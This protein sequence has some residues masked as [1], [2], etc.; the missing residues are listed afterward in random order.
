MAGGGCGLY[1]FE[2]NQRIV[3]L[4]HFIFLLSGIF[5]LCI[6][7]S[8]AATAAG[9]FYNRGVQATIN[10]SPGATTDFGDWAAWAN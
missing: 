10:V 7:F 1:P 3:Q 5:N 9:N 4:I 2:S 6:A 8:G